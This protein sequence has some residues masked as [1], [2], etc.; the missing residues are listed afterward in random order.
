MKDY[1]IFV[2]AF[3]AMLLLIPFLSAHTGRNVHS[4]TAKNA[5]SAAAAQAETV[6]SGSFVLYRSA[7]KTVETLSAEEYIIGVVMAEMPTSYPAEAL[8]AQAAAAYTFAVVRRAYRRAHPAAAKSIGGADVSDDPAHDQ[9]YWSKAQMVQKC[10]DEYDAD[11]AKVTA[12]VQA[13]RGLALTVNGEPIES[14]YFSCSSGRTESS[15]DVWGNDVSYLQETDSPW[16]VNASD[17][18]STVRV[19]AADFQSAAQ[20]RWAKAVLSG[21]A[22]GWCAVLSRT[23]AGGAR[24]VRVGGQEVSGTAVQALFGLRSSVFDVSYENGSFVFSV[25]GNG[26]GVGLSQYG[27]GALARQGKTWRQIVQYYY[28]GV[29]ITPYAWG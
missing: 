25:R 27:A 10:G 17:Y 15:A 23:G 18:G 22:S 7:T 6:S 1:R 26:H 2:A 19:S 24:R 20:A 13:V 29:N 12:A 16:D 8:K 21:D 28:A 14:V 3:S 4:Q 11:L 9:S 5:Q